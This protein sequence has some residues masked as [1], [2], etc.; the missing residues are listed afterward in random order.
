MRPF[1]PMLCAVGALADFFVSPSGSDSGDG[2]AAHPWATIA[3]AQ[4]GVRAAAPSMASDI[5]VWIAPGAYA[6]PTT[7]L[8][9]AADSG[10]N[11]YVVHW[12]STVPG[13]A[14]VHGGVQ[15]TGWA[16]LSGTN[17]AVWVAPL[18]ASVTEARQLYVAGQRAPQT[19]YGHGLQG[20]V[21]QTAWG[22]TTTDTTPASSW[23]TA[24]A[25]PGGAGIEFIYTGVG[26][27]WTEAHV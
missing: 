5:V 25:Q 11:G 22:Y 1:L 27:S 17:G 6:Q 10:V 23:A 15:V 3:R 2:S 19:V 14:V 13:S 12:R 8:F 16:P 9:S 24:A 21:T 20:T 4:V 18:P 26:S 7:L